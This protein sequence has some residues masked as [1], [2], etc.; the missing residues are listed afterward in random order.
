MATPKANMRTN[1]QSHSRPSKSDKPDRVANVHYEVACV[2]KTES[3]DGANGRSWYRYVIEGGY[4]PLT[5][6]RQG[7]Q[8][9][10]AKY[11]S[12]LAAELNVRSG[13]GTPSPW[14]PRQK[15]S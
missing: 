1:L 4:G 13:L 6:C 15:K 8:K 2:E 3:P 14:A 7:T 12:D 11:A 10:I 9:Q 5:G